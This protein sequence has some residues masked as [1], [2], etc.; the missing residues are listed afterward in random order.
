MRCRCRRPPW[1]SMGGT[2][3][4][5]TNPPKLQK[6]EGSVDVQGS[7]TASGGSWNG[8][9]SFML[10]IPMGD[11][12]ALRAVGTAKYISGWINR[13]VISP[14]DF[15]FPTGLYGTPGTPAACLYYFCN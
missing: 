10:N 4:L 15:P 2:I 12:V 9:G 13:Y 1:H 7:N 3:K 5:V 14:P 8:G 6:F 11:I